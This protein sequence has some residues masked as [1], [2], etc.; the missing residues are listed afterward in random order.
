MTFNIIRSK[1]P[2]VA[3]GGKGYIIHMRENETTYKKSC[4]D[5][6]GTGKRKY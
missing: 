6:S 2:C 5:C 1:Y 3:C 4:K